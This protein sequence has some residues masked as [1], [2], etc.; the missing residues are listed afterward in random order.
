MTCGYQHG[1]SPAMKEAERD[2]KGKSE[3]KTGCGGRGLVWTNETFSFNPITKFKSQP[4]HALNTL[5]NVLE[6]QMNTHMYCIAKCNNNKA[7]LIL[8]CTGKHA[9]THMHTCHLLWAEHLFSGPDKQQAGIQRSQKCHFSQKCVESNKDS[10][11]LGKV[12]HFIPLFSCCTTFMTV[13]E[14][15]WCIR[16]QITVSVRGNRHARRIHQSGLSTDRS[17]K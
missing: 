14:L 3:T 2:G 12:T 8:T 7:L 11:S 5:T 4:L 6:P 17:H 1:R 16:C 15:H 9:L 13:S 10:S